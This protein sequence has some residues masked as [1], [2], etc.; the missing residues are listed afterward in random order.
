[1]GPPNFM[2]AIARLKLLHSVNRLLKYA[3]DCNMLIPASAIAT[4]ESE[5]DHIR[6]WASTCNLKLNTS[7]SKEI[8][9]QG[10]AVGRVV[11]PPL[12]DGVERVDVLNVLG[13]ALGVAITCRLRMDRHIDHVCTRANQSLYAIKVLLAHGLSGERLYDV[14]R[15]TTLAR[16]LYAS[17]AW[18]GFANGAQRNRLNAVVRRLVRC[19]MLPR[20]QPSFENLCDR[21]DAVF[22]ASILAYSDHVLYG[23]LPPIKVSGYELRK[24]AHN[25]EIPRAD[26]FTRC[27]FI[28][29][30][31]YK[32]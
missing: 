6:S 20:D 21:S 31:L 24:R 14:V 30:M 18:Y 5:L 22:F 13:V 1:M 11:L 27:G 19:R 29:R 12:V 26:Y 7:K 25:R 4:T 17:S 32:I 10:L 15:A 8:I 23:L 16:M 2:V 3:D 9:I 28:V